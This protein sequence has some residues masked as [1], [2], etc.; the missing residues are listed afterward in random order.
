[1]FGHPRPARGRQLPLKSVRDL[2]KIP[3][4]WRLSQDALD[5]AKRRTS[6]AND[7]IDGLLD[8]PTLT[9][10]T[11][12]GFLTAVSQG[13]FASALRSRISWQVL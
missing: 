5:E 12:N 10:M 8:A 2:T 6:I 4:E 1:L 9:K 11:A 7:F 13:R 3:G